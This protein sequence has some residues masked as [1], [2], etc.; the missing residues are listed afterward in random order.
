[1]GRFRHTEWEITVLT[2]LLDP[3]E[4]NRLKRGKYSIATLWSENYFNII[5]CHNRAIQ[6][7]FPIRIF[8]KSFHWRY[9]VLKT[10]PTITQFSL[11]KTTDRWRRSHKSYSFHDNTLA[12]SFLEDLAT[13]IQI[14]S[15][16]LLWKKHLVILASKAIKRMEVFFID[17]ET[18]KDKQPQP[19]R[20]FP[21]RS[22]KGIVD[23]SQWFHCWQRSKEGPLEG[24]KKEMNMLFTCGWAV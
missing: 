13:W 12:F 15:W 17:G 19:R 24:L 3:I 5:S 1:M 21:S 10:S 8:S 14:E 11:L 22:N 18:W 9:L 7:G 4:S 6:A 2:V 20:P 16:T 23:C